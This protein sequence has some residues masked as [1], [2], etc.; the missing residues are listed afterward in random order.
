MNT[1]YGIQR[2]WIVQAAK[3]ITLSGRRASEVREKLD[4]PGRNCSFEELYFDSLARMELCIWMQTEVGVELGEDEILAHPSV[5]AL[6]AYLAGKTE[7]TQA[8]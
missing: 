6:A 2:G 8:S 7:S 5:N 1:D 3:A 4:D